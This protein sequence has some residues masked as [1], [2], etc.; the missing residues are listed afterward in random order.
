ME[1]KS[2]L[3]R[4][5]DLVA[6]V[7][8]KGGIVIFPTDTV[9]GV[10]CVVNNP[11]AIKRLYE[12]KKRDADKPTSL[13]IGQKKWV[14]D[15]ADH[16]SSEA[17]E[18]INRYWP[19]GLTL[20]FKAKKS[21]PRTIMGKGETVGLRMPNHPKLLEIINK[22]GCPILGPSANFSGEKPPNS[23][24]DLSTQL[25]E[26]GDLVFEGEAGQGAR[27]TIVDVTSKPFKVL[28]TGVV[29]IEINH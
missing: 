20:I 19:G 1:E 7:F 3:T 15:L 28:R 27:S 18:M 21:V 23:V 13:L 9:W 16:V 12:V 14:D 4:D 29:K 24:K 17:R 8:Q 10:G 22:V 26:G 6:R 2:K 5:T 25:I 11:Q